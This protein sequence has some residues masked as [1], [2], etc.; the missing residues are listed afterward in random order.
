MSLAT[1]SSPF[2]QSTSSSMDDSPH[3]RVKSHNKTQKSKHFD[4]DKQKVQS[5]LERIHQSTNDSDSSDNEE[6]FDNNNNTNPTP[7]HQNAFPPYPQSSKNEQL[8]LNDIRNYG[9]SKSADEY[10]R[11]ILPGYK[12]S[13]PSKNNQIPTDENILLQKLNYMIYLLEEQHDERTNNVTEEVVLY[14][15]LG[16]FMIF[17]VD[18]FFKGGKYVR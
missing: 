7:H 17:L 10:Y 14:S 15:F 13:M 12:Q 1:Y 9:D 8:D 6:G 16:V 2:L 11:R 5:I 18:T 4:I 3:S